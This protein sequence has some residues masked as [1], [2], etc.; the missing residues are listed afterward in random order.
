MKKQLGIVCLFFTMIYAQEEN[1]VHVAVRAIAHEKMNVF[2][3]Y[4]ADQTNE[5]LEKIA[6]VIA[7]DFQMMHF[8][9][10][11][12]HLDTSLTIS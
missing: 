9:K 5:Q 10:F 12:V 3:G 4:V 2:I 8:F 1:T 7:S 6:H 11:L